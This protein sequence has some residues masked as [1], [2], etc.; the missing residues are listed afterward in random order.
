[1]KTRRI[2][3]LLPAAVVVLA[4]AGAAIAAVHSTVTVK[5]ANN[6][7]LNTKI[8]VDQTNRTMYHITTDKGKKITCT[9]ACSGIWPPLTVAKGQKPKAGPGIS[10]SKLGTVKR[11]DGKTQVTYA[12]LTL[13]RYT[14]DSK[15]GQ[16]NGEGFE[17]IWYAVGPSGKL[18]K[19]AS[20]AASGGYGGSG[21]Y[22]NAP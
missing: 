7:T 19:S 12:G 16:T 9:G 17:K 15:S 2:R 21:G 5:A 14:G 20:P 1:M 18:V 8:V 13:Y 11:P 4:G 6:K 22:G 3:F 10:K